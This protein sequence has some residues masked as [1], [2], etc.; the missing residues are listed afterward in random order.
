MFAAGRVSSIHLRA[1]A[2]GHGRRSGRL[3]RGRSTLAADMLVV[4]GLPGAGRIPLLRNCERRLLS[5][6]GSVNGHAAYR[7]GEGRLEV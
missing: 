1:I 2:A 4:A 7:A 3:R 5:K 6:P